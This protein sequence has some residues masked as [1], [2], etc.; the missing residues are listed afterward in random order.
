[1]C[2]EKQ[3]VRSD[4][5]TNPLFRTKKLLHARSGFKNNKIITCRKDRKSYS[6]QLGEHEKLYPDLTFHH[7]GFY[8]QTVCVFCIPTTDR[9]TE[10]VRKKGER[11][12]ER[13]GRERERETERERDRD[14]PDT[15]RERETETETETQR[16]REIDT[17]FH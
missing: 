15:D 10:R 13:E 2:F 4:V 11:E 3:V 9:Q 12:G 14:R 16:E 17:D 8:Q 5:Q 1:M 7:F 6:W